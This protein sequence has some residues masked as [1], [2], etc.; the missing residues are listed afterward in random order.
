MKDRLKLQPGAVALNASA[1]AFRFYRSGTVKTCCNPNDSNCTEESIY[2]NHAVAI[3]GYS[4][5][6]SKK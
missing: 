6:T 4:D 2:I 5:G 1:D 3:V